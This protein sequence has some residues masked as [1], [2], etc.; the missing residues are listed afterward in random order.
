MNHGM[1]LQEVD[2]LKREIFSSLHCAMPGIVESFDAL[3]QTAA[4]RPALKR[5]GKVLPLIRDVPVFMP[6]SF[7]VYPGDACLLVFADFDTDAWLEGREAEEP[8]SGRMHSLSDAF[9]FIGF[10]RNGVVT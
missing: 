1:S 10:K 7:T 6:V 8:A 4:V 2:A 9:A 5:Q 3:T